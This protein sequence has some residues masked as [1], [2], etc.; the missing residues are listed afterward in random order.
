M[1]TSQDAPREDRCGHVVGSVGS[2]TPPAPRK[3]PVMTKNL[4][5]LGRI[6]CDNFCLSCNG[7]K[8]WRSVM[9]PCWMEPAARQSCRLLFLSGSVHGKARHGRSRTGWGAMGLERPRRRRGDRSPTRSLSWTTRTTVALRARS[10][11]GGPA[12]AAP[13]QVPHTP[14][15][16]PHNLDFRPGGGSNQIALTGAP[17]LPGEPGLLQGNAQRNAAVTAFG[18]ATQ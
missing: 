8:C 7:A 14:P 5:A 12:L 9:A 3:Y 1:R 18:H 4:R 11:L 10:F 17:R 6:S 13:P 2:R 15:W 16:Q